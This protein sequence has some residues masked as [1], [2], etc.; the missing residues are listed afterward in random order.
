R[1]PGPA[2][3]AGGAVVGGAAAPTAA[4]GVWGEGGAAGEP[5]AATPAAR[6]AGAAAAATRACVAVQSNK[7]ALVSALATILATR[8]R[9]RHAGPLYAHVPGVVAV[10]ALELA[11]ALGA[12]LVP[13]RIGIAMEVVDGFAGQIAA[14][15]P[16]GVCI[17]RARGEQIAVS[18]A[19]ADGVP[20]RVQI[21]PDGG[22]VAAPPGSTAAI[23]PAKPST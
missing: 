16:V 13:V 5:P 1:P 22:H 9:W 20:L 8:G 11:A 23:C 3:R 19:V 14:V 6:A 17:Q 10:R 7:L 2:P 18:G 4:G 21:A 15:E 12:L